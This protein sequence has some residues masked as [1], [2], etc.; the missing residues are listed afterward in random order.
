[1]ALTR[2]RTEATAKRGDDWRRSTAIMAARND[3][4]AAS[5]ACS[6]RPSH[7]S[8]ARQSAGLEIDWWQGSAGWRRGQWP[9]SFSNTARPAETRAQGVSALRHFNLPLSHPDLVSHPQPVTSCSLTHPSRLL[10]IHFHSHLT[11]LKPSLVDFSFA[12]RF[13][14][15]CSQPGRP[16]TAL[17][18]RV[19]GISSC[20]TQ[21]PITSPS[22]DLPAAK[23][24]VYRGTCCSAACFPTR[25][26]PHPRRAL[27]R[28]RPFF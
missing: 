26:W 10:A 20:C 15:C 21:H 16:L 3:M 1:M 4:P 12:L 25:R 18:S 11:Y 24:P 19:S 2:P 7:E 22:S 17:S 14:H 27:L 6:A 28:P 13:T 5:A 9:R 8:P 23:T